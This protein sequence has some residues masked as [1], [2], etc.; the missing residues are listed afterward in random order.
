MPDS[1]NNPMRYILQAVNYSVFMALIWF[2]SSA[3]SIRLLADDEAMLTI[4]F[5]HAGEL[6]E[7]CRTMSAEELA[8]L[9]ANMRISQDCPRERSP[10]E[11][12]ISMDG[13]QIY[14]KSLLPPGIYKDS[15]VNI[16]FSNKIPAG[17]HN[18]SISMEDNV[19]NEGYD[20]EFEQEI[21]VDPSQILLV[22]FDAEKGFVVK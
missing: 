9:P 6:R 12:D 20:Y 7:P 11:I 21:S 2:F 4:A 19:R 5:S 18:L 15:G 16:Y 10:I 17:R 3:P 1:N 22:D 14:N 8:K 13:K